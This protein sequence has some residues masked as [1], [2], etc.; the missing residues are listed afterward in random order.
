LGVWTFTFF[1][2]FS[3]FDSFYKLININLSLLVTTYFSQSVSCDAS[4]GVWGGGTKKGHNWLVLVKSAL[5]K[6]TARNIQSLFTHF[7]PTN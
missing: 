7:F 6:T 5:A 4:G 2:H 3:K 1:I